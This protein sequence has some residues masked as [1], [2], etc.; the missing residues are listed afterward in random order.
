MLKGIPAILSPELVKVLMEM[1]HGDMIL[2]CDANYP[3]LGCPERCVR[4]DSIGIPAILDAILTLMP[5]DALAEYP[6]IM[7]GVNP[8]DPYV[9]LVWEEYRQIGRKYEKDG[10]RETLIPNH[11]FYKK[12]TACYACVA[13]GER[14]MYGNIIL[15]KGV[16]RL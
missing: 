13:T 11:E 16:I 7:M 15:R 4:M 2:L 1:G 9:P 10:L 5:L 14:A 3:K 8:G 12:G 6:T